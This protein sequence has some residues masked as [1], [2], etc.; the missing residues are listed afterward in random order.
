MATAEMLCVYAYICI[1]ECVCMTQVLS[2]V[3]APEYPIN[4]LIQIQQA[5]AG[6]SIRLLQCLFL[7]IL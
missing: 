2:F 4:S 6:S 3:Q 1:N 7:I 5:N